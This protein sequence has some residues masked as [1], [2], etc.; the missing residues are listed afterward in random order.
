MAQCTMLVRLYSVLDFKYQCSRMEEA[1]SE[2]VSFTGFKIQNAATKSCMYLKI[3]TLWD[4]WHVSYTYIHSHRPSRR[5]QNL[6]SCMY[7]LHVH[8]HHQMY[9]VC[10]CMAI[11]T[12]CVYVRVGLACGV[13]LLGKLQRSTAELSEQRKAQ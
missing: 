10:T 13:C 1:V 11:Y 7:M 4:H 12:C 8:V 5:V 9:I 6:S 2:V 3:A